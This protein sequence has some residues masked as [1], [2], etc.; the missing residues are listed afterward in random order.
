[1]S[2]KP[3][4]FNTDMVR[5]ILDGRKTVT[6][7]VAFPG[8]D[9]CEFPRKEYPDGWWFRGRA[10]R[11]WDSAMRESQGVMSLCKYHPSDI[12]YVR[13]TWR[14]WRAHRY[15]ADAHIEFR[16]GGEGAVVRFPHGCTDSANRDD[17]DSFIHKWGV[18]ENKWRP[19]IHM[20]REAAR[21]F[22]RV[23]DVRV[24]RLQDITAE[25]IL[26]EG[27]EVKFPEPKP[28][29]ISLAYTEMRLKPAA[30][31]QFADL[32][33]RTIKKTDRALYDW[34][35]NPWVWVIEFEQISREEAQE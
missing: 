9:L 21:I 2:T 4:L 6:R 25:Q 24:E 1:M 23:T 20:P 8:K 10:Y 32:W 16:A 26:D 11:T 17:Y 33:D 13:E 29:Y 5:A 19:S 35:A 34:G 27:V 30:R 22:L 3:I 31:K 15:D 28:G 14:I 12:L 7:R 18:R